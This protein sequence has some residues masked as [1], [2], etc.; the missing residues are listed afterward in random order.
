L[1]AI[2]ANARVFLSMHCNAS[3]DPKPND[4]QIYY[5][6][7]QKDKP[8][9]EKLFAGVDKIDHDT[10]KWS[11]VIYGNFFVL[12][13]LNL[14]PIS[15]ALVEIGFISNPEDESLLNDIEFQNKFCYGLYNGLKLFLNIK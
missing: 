10:S 12:R 5:H 11:R 7:D 15:A 3:V 13:K 6:N 1:F 14:H 8:L 9:A 2:D 4:C